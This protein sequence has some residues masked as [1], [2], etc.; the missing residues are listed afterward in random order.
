[1][2]GGGKKGGKQVI[3]YNY[4]A[5]VHMVLTHS[6]P[7]DMNRIY[8]GEKLAW[9]GS[10]VR[11]G[12][13]GFESYRYLNNVGFSFNGT[14]GLGD[15]DVGTST[16]SETIAYSD[17][18]GQGVNTSVSVKNDGTLTP[19]W[20][21]A[22]S[23][24]CLVSFGP[25]GQ[26]A[27]TPQT[28][29]PGSFYRGSVALRPQTR[30][31]D[32]DL[33]ELIAIPGLRYY[34][35]LDIFLTDLERTSETVLQFWCIVPGHS[36]SRIMVTATLSTTIWHLVGG[37]EGEL[38]PYAVELPLAKSVRLS[39]NVYNEYTATTLV[40]VDEDLGLV[41]YFSSVTATFNAVKSN[42]GVWTVQVILS[43][44]TYSFTMPFAADLYSTN[45][46]DSRCSFATKGFYVGGDPEDLGRTVTK[47]LD[48]YFA[49]YHTATIDVTNDRPYGDGLTIPSIDVNKRDLFGGKKREG[50]VW[51]KVWAMFGWNDQPINYHMYP[52]TT[53]SIPA[54]RGVF[55]LF[56]Q[57]FCWGMSHYLKPV[58]VTATRI[59]RTAE[60][61]PN[62][63][64]EKA[65]WPEG[66][67]CFGDM[68]PAH[69][70]YECLTDPV[71]GA[72]AGGNDLTEPDE[73]TF[74]AAADT[75]Y[76][77]GFGL[78]IIWQQESSIE[79]FIQEIIRHIDAALYDDPFTGKTKLKLIRGG[80]ILNDLPI[81]DRS[82]S[83]I[84]N[85]SYG[86]PLNSINE[87]TVV[88]NKRSGDPRVT[89]IPDRETSVS[90]RDIS[91]IRD[92]DTRN[93]QT[94]EYPGITT[95]ANANRVAQR[96]LAQVLTPPNMFTV[97][98]NRKNY[99]LM[100]GDVFRLQD[101]DR[102]IIDVVCRVGRRTD[103]AYTDGKITIDCVEDVFA[104][105]YGVYDAP[106]DSGWVDEANVLNNLDHA[107][108]MELPYGVALAAVGGA[109]NL[110]L[111][112]PS[113][114]F[115]GYFAAEPDEGV[116][117]DYRLTTAL[118]VNERDP[119]VSDTTAQF[120]LSYEVLVAL[121][122]DE[123]ILVL[124]NGPKG[125]VSLIEA[126][127]LLVIGGFPKGTLVD[128]DL[129]PE[130]VSIASVLGGGT[131]EI[132][133]GCYDT[134]PSSHVPAG[135]R[136][137]DMALAGVRSD[138]FDG[139]TM[140]M[141]GLPATMSGVYFN[142][143]NSEYYR[144]AVEIDDRLNR[145][146]P[147]ARVLANS[148]YT[149]T[150]YQSSMADVTF[151][152]RHR[153]RI[154]Q[155]D[156]GISYFDNSNIG[157]EVGVTYTLEWKGGHE[158]TYHVI[159]GITGNSTVFTT[160]IELT[161]SAYFTDPGHAFFT[162]SDGRFDAQPSIYPVVDFRLKSVRDGLDS[163]KFLSFRIQRS[164]YGFNY[165]DYYGAP[166]PS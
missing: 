112:D 114:R 108:I 155:Q 136:V 2:G 100:P 113:A 59:K 131:F 72:K 156:Y 160:A 68:N 91:A 86:N 134:I 23:A 165:G 41:D 11:P 28:M 102:G 75:L 3:G 33:L 152:W 148:T 154:T 106:A 76:N 65:T 97:E 17:R 157:P 166:R 128:K 107:T 8:M 126:G 48:T 105:L 67:P 46:V 124:G 151:D 139:D 153:D 31:S 21:N 58:K 93:N 115:A 145:P 98:L 109:Y 22:N 40:S 96:D 50:G 92:C 123:T 43:G 45:T 89:D 99:N 26:Y 16:S 94:N 7:D 143:F 122:F 34:S 18:S 20:Q 111:I 83:R 57:D 1:M 95:D 69:I 110:S 13:D 90:V 125:D 5:D 61:I 60:D 44:Q 27:T 9:Q 162:A 55:S 54:Y 24:T 81:L 119:A 130:I 35:P 85:I 14:G 163:Y 56:F 144:L 38:S 53:V 10:I 140:N 159:S 135:S 164:G 117:L 39:F 29:V 80:Y 142:E 116:Y 132:L 120:T 4:Y 52:I 149:T 133:R 141:T 32:N 42:A 147:P 118:L 79:E 84:I 63:Y 137:F 104:R 88:Y 6:L 158:A 121:D 73:D 71:W 37:T 127:D 74:I 51:G 36:P 129:A 12:P 150:K 78:S 66:H 49:A 15:V 25:F 101:P 146:Y 70:I 161:G 19:N 47:T 64:P 138:A 62:W 103:T 87:V 82:N 30:N 77:E